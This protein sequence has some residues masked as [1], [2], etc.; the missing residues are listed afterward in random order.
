MANTE[1]I[2]KL[3]SDEA[4]KGLDALNAK[5]ISSYNEMETLL[6]KTQELS[7]ELSSPAKSYAELNKIIENS[8]KV[9]RDKNSVMEDQKKI[10][11]EKNKLIEQTVKA[12]KE[13][14]QTML[15]D[16]KVSKEVDKL[17]K[18]MLGTRE[19]NARLLAREKDQLKLLAAERAKVNKQEQ[20]G[21]INA[22]DALNARS[23]LIMRENELKQAISELQITLKNEQKLLNAADGT[24]TKHRLNLE[25]MRMAYRQLTDE[26]KKSAVGQELFNTINKFDD[27]VKR[28][29][30]SVGNWQQNVGNYAKG[31]RDLGRII[32]LINPELGGYVSRVQ[33]IT[34]VTE[35]WGKANKKLT[36]TLNIST[37]A[38]KALMVTGVG[39]LIALIAILVG[40]YKTWKEVQ[41]DVARERAEVNKSIREEVV[42][43]RSLESIL[44]DSNKEYKTR[45]YALDELK[46]IMPNYNAM[47]DAEGRLIEDNTGSLKKY[48]QQIKS[49]AE[50]KIASEKLVA[51]EN[52]FDEWVAGLSER[53]QGVLLS[54]DSRMSQATDDYAY[55]VLSEKRDKYLSDIEKWEKRLE[56][57]QSESFVK[58]EV[59]RGTK[60]YWEQQQAAAKSLLD[61]MKDTDR[62][63]KE[64]IDAVNA[65]N[66]ASKKLEI[67]NLSTRQV[68]NEKADPEI[69]AAQDVALLRIRIE[70]DTQKQIADDATKS[71]EERF[72]SMVAYQE[73][74]VAYIE[75][76]R[77][78]QLKSEK[79]SQSGR[80]LVNLT[81]DEKIKQ[82]K[83]ELYESI[84]A[85]DKDC[86]NKLY[87]NSQ[88]HLKSLES[89]N[90]R[91][92]QGELVTLSKAY[93]AGE[94]KKEAYEKKK[95]EIGKKYAVQTFETEIS[96]LED[97]LLKFEENENIREQIAKQLA[98]AREDY[99]KYAANAEI[100]ANEESVKKQKDAYD[101]LK[102]YLETEYA[103]S[104]QGAWDMM[105]E[106]SNSYYDNQ[107]SRI[108]ELEK[109]EQEYYDEKLKTI[110]ENLEAGM[111]SEEAADA[112]R[113]I[114]EESQLQRE[115]EYEKQRKEMQRKQAAWQKANAI[116]QA[117]INTGVAFTSALGLFP[118]PLG[119]AMAAIVGALGAAQVAMIASKSVPAYAEGTKGQGHP[120]GFAVVGD[121]GRPEM[122]LT[123]SGQ[124][125]KTPP[126]DTLA[127]LPKGAEVF[128]DFRQAMENLLMRPAVRGY[129]DKSEMILAYD[130]VLR[131][132]TGKT[133]RHLSNINEG[134]HAIRSNSMYS[135]KKLDVM[136]RLKKYGNNV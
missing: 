129:D 39:A 67:W 85:L 20:A 136:Y 121:G 7:T 119:I 21:R 29:S 12:T 122:V 112:R 34:S 24:Y 56:K 103:K 78:F 1:M 16:L 40:W 133:N 101:V 69:K 117:M 128:P 70:S 82:S 55:K 57:S 105:I 6:A 76:Q 72:S 53:E 109:R 9:E 74:Q 62:G 89:D 11:E 23:D 47:L 68:K 94:I 49:V 125:W 25:R 45:K 113:R 107:I 120:G 88:T 22:K 35:L 97:E 86:Y 8:V 95:V 46:K 124:V 13:N 37:K 93:A 104:I 26:Q 84:N 77:E 83:K 115:K 114:I 17:V 110:D 42:N 2:D 132:N 30:E 75:K 60:E 32:S 100:K 27:A 71:Y 51:A 58:P 64:W 98:K 18:Q 28:S 81:A 123:P 54:G 14:T 135:Q 63:S 108:D 3:V 134:I 79:L 66:R 50:A 116:I 126:V 33:S 38:T 92:E 61:T 31:H 99:A 90:A 65:Y 48:I 111:M 59:A 106:V 127:Y 87:Q 4:L 15:S 102:E 10:I 52:A 43:V 118:P 96:Y 80:E 44:R 41:E 130:D 36:T 91:A 73:K 131:E 5:L 19:Q